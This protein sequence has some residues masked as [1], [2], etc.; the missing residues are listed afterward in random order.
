MLQLTEEQ[1]VSKYESLSPKLKEV[2]GSD[3]YL[4]RIQNIGKQFDLSADDVSVLTTATGYVVLGLVPPDNL[5]KE[6]NDYLDADE[7]T[8]V[9]VIREINRQIL[10]PLHSE[11]EKLY[12]LPT[13]IEETIK[14]EEVK[15]PE[16][17]KV[18][19]KTVA[20]KPEAPAS[21][22]LKPLILHEEKSFGA[23]QDKPKA[24]PKPFSFP[25]KVFPAK[26]KAPA[27]PA[28][29]ARVEGPERV[30]HYS[31]LRTLLEPFGK[32][33]EVINLETFQAEKSK[34][35][36]APAPKPEVKPETKTE[37]KPQPKIDGNVVSLK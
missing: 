24:A 10:F 16:P 4:E 13:H 35:T 21:G 6:V 36:P 28:V 18:E 14:L 25:F 23:A 3:F 27:P 9:E 31:E 29:K 7:R 8:V 20:P 12:K 11:L 15:I 34:P 32:E 17:Q 37:E 5:F 30:V 19:I 2:L 1:I 33:E 22:E 26:P